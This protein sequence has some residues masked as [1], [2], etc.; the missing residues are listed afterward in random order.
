[1]MRHPAKSDLASPA[2]KSA[3]V[4]CT[5]VVIL[6]TCAWLIAGIEAVLIVMITTMLSVFMMPVI[7]VHAIMKLSRGRLVEPW[8]SPE[9]HEIVTSLSKRAGLQSIPSLYWLPIANISAFSVGSSRKGGLAI[10]D[11]AFRNL[12]VQELTG[13]VA[14]E[15]SHLASGDSY[16]MVASEIIRRITAFVAILALA[17]IFA[18]AVSSSQ[19]TVPLWMPVFF[20]L[21]PT[22]LILCQLALSRSREYAA[23]ANAVQLTND[24]AGLASALLKIERAN[25]RRWFWEI[26]KGASFDV[27]I[28]LQSH[29]P[30]EKRIERLLGWSFASSPEINGH[31][32]HLPRRVGISV[33]PHS[34]T[35][36]EYY[37]HKLPDWRFQL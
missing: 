11:G 28:I 21:A 1:M 14:H 32:T 22:S 23:D 13:V 17:L 20:V 18:I 25:L 29:P 3:L 4:F 36:R 31:R 6:V 10:S 34:T 26:G 8:Y 27:P 37:K 2:L 7:P 33:K 24:P 5:M 35:L 19:S 16:L 15:I 12:T 9:L 30:T